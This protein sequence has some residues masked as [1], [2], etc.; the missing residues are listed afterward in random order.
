MASRSPKT[1]A[2][3]DT[4]QHFP[5][6]V[7]SERTGVGAS[8][9]RAWER[10]YA[11]LK[12][13]RTPKGHRLY[14]EQ[15]VRIVERVLLLLEEGH[16]LSAIAREILQ[17]RLPVA[18]AEDKL[19]QSGVWHDYL[20]GTLQAVR[21]FSHERIEAIFNDAS[22][23]YPIDMV[24]ERLVEP[25]LI[26]LGEEWGRSSSGIAEEH[27]YTSWVRNR[28]GARFHHGYNQARGARI[29]CACVPGAYHDIGLML[30]AIAAMTRGYRVLYF[31][32]DLPLEQIEPVVK[33]SG[34]RAVV[35]SAREPLDGQ[36]DEQLAGMIG[37]AGVPVF[38]GGNAADVG[39][40]A[41]EAAGGVRLGSRISAALQVLTAR[42]EV[43]GAGSSREGRPRPT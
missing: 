35:L 16:S 32:P 5:I 20:H 26:T 11:L 19:S 25:V 18:N 9:L 15:H 17:G 1:L 7:L 34:A 6:R 28:L 38:L 42:V 21:D 14:S 29:V 40:P 37:K 30:F 4:M 12:P 33:K 22:S 43:H 2:A 27:F 8:T 13:E 36:D 10:R 3:S 24:T 39:V 41:F 31:G 23:L